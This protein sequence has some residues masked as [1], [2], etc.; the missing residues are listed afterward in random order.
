[1]KQTQHCDT[2]SWIGT[3][4]QR[5]QNKDAGRSPITRTMREQ[6]QKWLQKVIL[7]HLDSKV[8][9]KMLLHICLLLQGGSDS[10]F[11]MPALLSA[12]RDNKNSHSTRFL[13]IPFPCKGAWC[14][15][16]STSEKKYLAVERGWCVP[17][18]QSTVDPG[19]G[20]IT[21]KPRTWSLPKSLCINT[22]QP[23]MV[24]SWQ[25]ERAGHATL[26]LDPLGG[27]SAGGR[28]ISSLWSP[29]P[30]LLKMHWVCS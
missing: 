17:T 10:T 29:S 1:M 21:C 8:T 30:W 26:L 23:S 5:F 18:S 22:M 27:Q 28:A 2:T 13:E 24:R 6:F 7:C 4:R 3:S 15:K 16:L 12:F 9:W 19:M 11:E 25:P 20:E 14:T